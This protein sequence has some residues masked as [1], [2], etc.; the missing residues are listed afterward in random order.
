[1]AQCFYDICK[2]V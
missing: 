1:M 2:L